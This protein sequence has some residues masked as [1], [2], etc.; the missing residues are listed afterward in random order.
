[1]CMTPTAHQ[2]NT[3]TQFPKTDEGRRHAPN[4]VSPRQHFPSASLTT[5]LTPISGRGVARWLER[6]FEG[7]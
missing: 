7:S 3:G 2:S 5:D 6:L 1:M 4:E